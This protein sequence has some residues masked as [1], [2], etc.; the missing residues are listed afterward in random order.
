[1]FCKNGKCDLN[2]FDFCRCPKTKEEQAHHDMV[3]KAAD[4][5]MKK[6]YKLLKRLK[7]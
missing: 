5:V 3:M 2:M 4:R 7:D 6:H 1:M